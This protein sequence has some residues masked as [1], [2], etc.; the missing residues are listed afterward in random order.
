MQTDESDASGNWEAVKVCT[1]CGQEKPIEAFFASHLDK[2]RRKWK[3][4]CKVCTAER[5]GVGRLRTSSP[6]SSACATFPAPR[7]A[8]GVGSTSRSP[9]SAGP[10]KKRAHGRVALAFSPR[11]LTCRSAAKMAQRARK[12]EGYP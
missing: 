3:G 4:A 8:Q 10:P 7:P 2:K 11:C 6:A 5:Q 9:T 12:A 1:A